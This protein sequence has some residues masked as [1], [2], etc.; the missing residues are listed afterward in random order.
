MFDN[1]FSSI[2]DPSVANIKDLIYFCKFAH[3]IFYSQLFNS[4]DMSLNLFI[5]G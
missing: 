4:S 3:F 5:I 1:L 2:K